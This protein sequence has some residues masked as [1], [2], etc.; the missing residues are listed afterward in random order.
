MSRHIKYPVWKGDLD[1]LLQKRFRIGI[2]DCLDE[3][4]LK[5]SFNDGESPW[6]VSTNLKVKR[7]LTEYEGKEGA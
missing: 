3:F 7:E 6:E 4:L 1:M 2:R 5:E